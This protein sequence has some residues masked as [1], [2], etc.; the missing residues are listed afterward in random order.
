MDDDNLQFPQKLCIITNKKSP[1]LA[2]EAK[3]PF[4]EGFSCEAYASYCN[5]QRRHLCGIIYAKLYLISQKSQEKFFKKG[6]GKWKRQTILH[7]VST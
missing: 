6:G 5:K 2:R 4:K 3:V 7:S 1:P